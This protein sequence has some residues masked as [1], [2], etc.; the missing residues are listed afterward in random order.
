ME[1]LALT[2]ITRRE[3]WRRRGWWRSFI[4]RC[5]HSNDLIFVNQSYQ[6]RQQKVT[7]NVSK[8]GKKKNMYTTAITTTTTKRNK[9]V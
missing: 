5:T 8:Q 1:N 9:N 4:I 2:C 7:F 3:I 6:E